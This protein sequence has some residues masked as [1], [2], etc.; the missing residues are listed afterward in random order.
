MAKIE[1]VS[2]VSIN[3]NTITAAENADYNALPSALS[4]L[5]ADVAVQTGMVTTFTHKP[6][7]GV[8]TATDPKGETVTY[9]YDEFGRLVLVRDNE[10]KIISETQYNYSGI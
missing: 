7:A 5:R 8:E 6:L 1:G 3:Q 2:R 9:E 10:G 4:T